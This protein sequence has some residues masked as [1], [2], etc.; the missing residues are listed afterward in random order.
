MPPIDAREFAVWIAR[1]L[2]EHGHIAYF[3]GGCVRD[4]LLG[5]QPTDYDLA[6]DALPDRIK[7]LFRSAIGVGESFGVVLVRRGELFVE[8]AT[9]RSDGTYSDGRRPDSVSFGDEVAD[10]ARRDFTINALFEDPVDETIIDHFNGRSDL[11]ARILRA[12]GDPDQRLD[13]DRLRV[14]RAIRF[15]ARFELSIEAATSEAI[16]RHASMLEGVSRER[17]G[18]E[19]RKMLSNPGRSTAVRLLEQYELDREVLG[20]VRTRPAVFELIERMPEAPCDPMDALA[21]WLLDRGGIAGSD[22]IGLLRTRL[23]LSNQETR[24]LE[25]ILELFSELLERWVTLVVAPRKRLA[26]DPLFASALELVRRR[27]PQLAQVIDTDLEGLARTGIAPVPLVDGDDLVEAGLTPGPLFR[28]ILDGVYD[29]QL[30]Q[31][32]EDQPAALKLALQLAT[33]FNREATP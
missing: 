17:I 21:A 8:V 27:D 11:Q 19:L 26:A 2:R 7:S 18:Q 9:F 23:M 28:R 33:E 6:T 15:A 32:V 29:A 13:E 10:A 24:H 1:R 5:L 25:R 12:V 14:L 31:R 30:E 3:A 20:S 22:S 4:R 16:A